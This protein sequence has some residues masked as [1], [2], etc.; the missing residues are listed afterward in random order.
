MS[1]SR[2]TTTAWEGIARFPGVIESI[3]DAQLARTTI[4]NNAVAYKEF[5][6][7]PR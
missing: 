5:D 6:N 1:L 4:G 2:I 3:V 7:A